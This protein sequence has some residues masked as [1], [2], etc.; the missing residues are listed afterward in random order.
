TGQPAADRDESIARAGLKTRKRA[1]T[2]WRDASYRRS[3][4]RRVRRELSRREERTRTARRE[5]SRELTTGAW[6]RL[7]FADDIRDYCEGIG[8]AERGLRPRA[9]RRVD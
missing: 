1:K 6:A 9:G 2:H 3:P 5:I 8:L 7:L 4:L